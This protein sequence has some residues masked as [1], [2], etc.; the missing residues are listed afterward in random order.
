ME[1]FD[2]KEEVMDIKLTQYGKHLLS[3]GKFKP[4]FYAFF[5]DDILYDLRWSFLDTETTRAEEPQNNIEL[6]I[7]DSPRFKTQYVFSGIETQITGNILEGD[8]CG[9]LG[10]KCIIQPGPE[11][12][13]SL[14]LPIGTSDISNIFAPAW[15]VRYLNGN[16]TGSESFITASHMSAVRIPQLSSSIRFETYVS[17]V[18]GEGMAIKK[19]VDDDYDFFGVGEHALDEDVAPGTY[20]DGSFIEIKP[21]YIFLEVDEKNTEFAKENFEVEVYKVDPEGKEERLYFFNPDLQQNGE[22]EIKPHHVEYYLDISIDDEIDPVYYCKSTNVRQR[23]NILSDQDVPF[24]CDEVAQ[25]LAG[26]IYDIEDE[27]LEDRC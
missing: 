13:Y 6:R 23:Q 15:N 12:N 5:D 16:L 24:K 17:F 21:D 14:F 11:K 3:K 26:N 7:K 22:N 2:R 19:N 4:E 8:V 27:D 18:D 10:D 1:F 20:I 9:D 25:P